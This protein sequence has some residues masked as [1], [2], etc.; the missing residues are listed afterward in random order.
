M[1][2]RLNRILKRV[3]KPARYTGGEYHEIVKDLSGVSQR[4][5]LCFPDTYEIGMSNLGMRIL[6]GL[7]NRRSDIWCERVF[8]PWRDMEQEMRQA[9]IPLYALESGERYDRYIAKRFKSNQQYS[10]A[11]DAAEA[12]YP[13]KT[14]FAFR[15]AK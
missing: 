6:Y 11:L 10:D 9:S 14:T 15:F 7:F 2:S 12:D 13:V 3:Q 8:A 5:A 4:I 1:D